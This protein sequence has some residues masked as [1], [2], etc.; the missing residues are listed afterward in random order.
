MP[1]GASSYMPVI[2]PETVLVAFSSFVTDLNHNRDGEIG[3][4]L[5]FGELANV[6]ASTPVMVPIFG[7]G[8]A[9]WFTGSTYGIYGQRYTRY[10]AL[11]K[12]QVGQQ[13]HDKEEV[14]LSLKTYSIR[15]GIEYKVLESD[16]RKNYGKC[17]EFGN[18]CTWLIRISL[19]QRRGIWEVKRYNRPHICLTTSISSDHRM[20]DY[21]VISAFILPMIRAD[22]AV[23]IKITMPG[24]VAVLRTSLVRVGGKLNESSTYFHRLFWIFSPCIEA[25][26]QCKSLVSVNGT[27]LYGKYGGVLLV[28][29]AQAGNSNIILVA[30]ALVEGENAES[31]SFFLT[32]LW[33]LVMSQLGILVISDR[34][35][36]IKATLED[37]DG[38]WLP[39]MHTGHFV[40]DTWR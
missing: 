36:G 26:Q 12:F 32:Y 10:R 31:W 8:G 38:G 17:K 2:A 23:S 25:F 30:F 15:C 4:T 34:H 22:V 9:S 28:A 39:L 18:E 20:L 14:V 7:E 21:H 40:S 11:A 1:Q 35:N 16:H 3:D 24:S 27:H 33:Q 6:M 29:I 19:H 5:A 13:F 37:L